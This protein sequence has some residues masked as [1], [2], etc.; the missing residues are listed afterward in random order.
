MKLSS[1]WGRG[2]GLLLLCWCAAASA[3]PNPNP[4][5]M[6]G[7]QGL[8][9]ALPPAAPWTVEQREAL[10]KRWRREGVLRPIVLSLLRIEF[11][12][13]APIAAIESAPLHIGGAAPRERAAI[14]GMGPAARWML[15]QNYLA[16]GDAAKAKR[17]LGEYIEASQNV[18]GAQEMSLALV[19]TARLYSEL[20]D[21]QKAQALYQQ[22]AQHGNGWATGMALWDQANALIHEGR[23]EQARKLLMTP[24]TG[25]YADQ[26][27]V[28]LLSLLS[29][30]YY[31]SG[32]WEEAQKHSRETI[33]HY[34]SL[35]HPLEGEGQERE[36]DRAKEI[37]RWIEVWKKEPI[38]CMP[39]K[40]PHVGTMSRAELEKLGL[41]CI[42]RLS[43][44]TFQR[45]ALKAATDKAN[46]TARIEE[47]NWGGD[48]QLYF[49][50]E[51][52]IEVPLE[53]LDKNFDMTLTVSSP[54]FPGF[55]ARVPIHVEVPT[56]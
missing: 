53:M 41:P 10:L 36:L 24:I 35:E 8:P 11:T 25:Q 50:R 6:F 34:K 21:P 28:G 13:P 14:S 33:A 42:I 23:H 56:P 55:E 30:S 40:L 16:L 4:T 45:I 15:V 19:E 52:A 54:A 12:P 51:V 31:R 26:I 22:V 47:N 1:C 3:Q 44:H 9:E 32:E 7:R 49:Q 2:C 37:V 38:I 29:Y 46:V 27:K 39:R 43:V 20:G 48:N 18:L 5:D 17:A